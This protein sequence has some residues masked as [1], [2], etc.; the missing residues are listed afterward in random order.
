MAE[1]LICAKGG[2]AYAEARRLERV[3]LFQAREARDNKRDRGHR[4]RV[5]G[6]IAAHA[7]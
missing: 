6:I 5:A 7:A 3:S 4:R 1:A 2:D